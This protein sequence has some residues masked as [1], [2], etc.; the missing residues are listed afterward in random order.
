[1]AKKKEDKKI[2]KKEEKKKV[3]ETFPVLQLI[4]ES[5]EDNAIVV[6]ALNQNGLYLQFMKDLE[7][8]TTNL[9]LSK[10][11]FDKMIKNF[12]YGGL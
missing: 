1:M 12:K 5:N 11:E 3:V 8:D 10:D 9:K 2:E 6:G 4:A 7:K